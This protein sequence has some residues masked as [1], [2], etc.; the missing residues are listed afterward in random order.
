MYYLLGYR[1]GK[2]SEERIKQYLKE[3][4]FDEHITW[5]TKKRDGK[6]GKSQIFNFLDD[7]VLYRVCI[8]QLIYAY[9]LRK[10]T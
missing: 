5:D 7:E 2:E 8:T 3:E 10:S 9:L 1:I 4:K 6:F